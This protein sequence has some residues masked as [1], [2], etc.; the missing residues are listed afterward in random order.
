MRALLIII[1]KDQNKIRRY[2]TGSS[3][4]QIRIVVSSEQTGYYKLSD[5]YKHVPI[6]KQ[7]VYQTKKTKIF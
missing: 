1:G 5:L 4:L 6:E 3:S 2:W 7:S